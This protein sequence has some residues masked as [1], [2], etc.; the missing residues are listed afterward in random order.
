MFLGSESRTKQIK[1]KFFSK[2]HCNVFNGFWDFVMNEWTVVFA[3]CKYRLE[4]CTYLINKWSEKGK[5]G[6]NS[7]LWFIFNNFLWIYAINCLC[8]L[9]IIIVAT[10]RRAAG[11]G[12][13]YYIIL[14]IIVYL[15]WTWQPCL[16]I[17]SFNLNSLWKRKCVWFFIFLYEINFV[18]YLYHVSNCFWWR[19]CF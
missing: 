15:G 16:L 4:L 9:C 18:Y 3:R 1:W 8:I 12:D 6:G 17:M 5:Y 11:I 2:L 19:R 10:W 7:H 13:W 14:Y